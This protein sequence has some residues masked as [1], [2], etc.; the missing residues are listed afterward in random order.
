[1]NPAL[2]RTSRDLAADEPAGRE[3]EPIPGTDADTFSGSDT[4]TKDRGERVGDRGRK[5]NPDIPAD[6]RMGLRPT[7][8]GDAAPDRP[9]YPVSGALTRMAVG[10]VAGLAAGAI[11]VAI[12]YLL[13]LARVLPDPSFYYT[14]QAWFGDRGPAMTHG[15]GAAATI[16]GGG[17][18]GLLFGLIV[19]RPT[20]AKGIVFGLLP[21]ICTFLIAPM[22][23]APLIAALIL[24]VFV[25]GFALGRL[26]SWW[27]RPPSTSD[28]T[29]G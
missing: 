21:A 16:I 5:F 3:P 20:P 22:G 12:T 25:Y 24:N 19:R 11:V 10:F 26:A 28:T 23:R 13:M 29:P 9:A 6:E 8:P 4:D 27:L 2:G 18:W 7:V 15:F 17:L 14:S 1:M